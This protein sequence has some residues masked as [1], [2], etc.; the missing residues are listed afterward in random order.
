MKRLA[1]MIALMLIALSGL[2]L[3]E[4]ASGYFAQ[5]AV[6]FTIPS[7]PTTNPGTLVTLASIAVPPGYFLITARV[8]G[9]SYGP[10]SGAVC[11]FTDAI[12]GTA[13]NYQTLNTSS[14]WT[15]LQTA[16]SVMLSKYHGGANTTLTLSCQKG[17]TF[18]NSSLFSGTLM[19]VRV[20]SLN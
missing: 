12:A 3:A 10:N 18:T 16:S 1:L 20:S 4:D 17:Y 14:D 7:G 15:K 5:S 19:A 11:F 9:Q 8:D 6:P 13:W 2:A